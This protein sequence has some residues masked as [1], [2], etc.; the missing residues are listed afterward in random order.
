MVDIGYGAM[1]QLL[2]TGH[3][4]VDVS[5]VFITHHHW[6][7]D[8]DL[9]ALIGFNWVEGRQSPLPIHGPYGT[10]Q[11]VEGALDYFMVPER[12][13][14][15]PMKNAHLASEFVQAHEVLKDGEFYRDNN[16]VVTAAE[17]THYQTFDAGKDKP[18]SYRFDTPHRSVVFTGDTGYSDAVIELAKGADVLVSEV[19]DADA[20]VK[21]AVGDS[22]LAESALAGVKAH[23]WKEHLPPENVGKM[24]AKAGVK[25][26]VLTHF[27]PGLDSESDAERYTAA[28]RQFYSGP[29]IAGRDL[30]EI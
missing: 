13:F 14:A 5:G 1:H 2:F 4:P 18:F 24:A 27:A 16:V 21:L 23:M 28:V 7:H 15:A 20:A 12:I 3:R 8:A 29:V 9:A 6:D 22:H 26:V 11:M 10:K 17:N 30:L 19:I 25:M